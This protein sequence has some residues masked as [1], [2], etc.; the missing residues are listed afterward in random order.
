MQV[1]KPQQ[2]FIENATQEQKKAIQKIVNAPGMGEL[3]S[4]LNIMNAANDMKNQI[5]KEEI[6]KTP[7]KPSSFW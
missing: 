7:E 4:D 1:R 5:E 6:Q 2:D 3:R